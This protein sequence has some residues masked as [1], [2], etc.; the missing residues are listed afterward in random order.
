[1]R[2]DERTDAQFG[3]APADLVTTLER[4]GYR[5]YLV[6]PGRLV[7]WTAGDFQTQALVDLLA[8][9][10]VPRELRTSCRVDGPLTHD[11]RCQRAAADARHAVADVREAVGRLLA[12]APAATL[13]DPRVR[14]ALAG[15]A[16]DPEPRVRAAVEWWR[17]AGHADEPGAGA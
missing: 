4:Q 15:L 7:P 12:G 9:R 10:N 3:A 5:H 6:E 1:M 8:I 16:D 17:S 14:A 13:A 11:E 2:E